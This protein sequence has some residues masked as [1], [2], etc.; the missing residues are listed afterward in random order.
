MFTLDRRLRYQNHPG[1]SYILAAVS[2]WASWHVSEMRLGSLMSRQTFSAIGHLLADL[3][4]PDLSVSFLNVGLRAIGVTLASAVLA[5]GI[6]VLLGLPLGIL[7]SGQLWDGGDSQLTVWR[8]RLTAFTGVAP[9]TR[10]LL[11]ITRS[12]PDLVWAL[13]FVSAFGLGPLAG[14]CALVICYTAILGRVY[15]ELLDEVAGGPMRSLEAIGAS[16]LQLLTAVLLPE[17]FPRLLAYTLFTF[18]CCVRSAIVLGFVGAGGIG[19]EISLSMRLFEYGQVST[20][21]LLLFG[22]VLLIDASSRWI[23]YLISPQA[24]QSDSFSPRGKQIAV[25]TM[26]TLAA[27][28][29]A[30]APFVFADIRFRADIG[31]TAASFVRQF[32]PIDLSHVFLRH[33]GKGLLETLAISLLATVFG[34]LGALAFGPLAADTRRLDPDVTSTAA[35]STAFRHTL[36]RA[37]RALLAIERSIPDLVWALCCILAVGFGPCAGTLA[38][39]IHT[40]GVMGKLVADT[41]EE[42]SPGPPRALRTLGATRLQTLLWSVWPAVRLTLFNYTMLR[43]DMN[44]RAATILGLV[45]GGGLGQLLYNSVQL[46]FYQQV[47]TAIVVICVVV[48]CSDYVA[49]RSKYSCSSVWQSM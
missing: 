31:A 6:A 37:T 18:E 32:F 10:S 46:G 40:M 9:L 45:G 27:V 23:R 48:L 21:L 30:Y 43:W 22:T 42:S 16:R 12:I 7:A 17:A 36:S 47:G 28:G 29:A 3:F 25:A 49:S 1:Y 20:L 26:V 5:T 2:I 33:L 34:T 4:P 39:S 41:I 11:S 15:G 24:R 35:W 13:L 44:L 19:Y 8:G 14:I 38:L